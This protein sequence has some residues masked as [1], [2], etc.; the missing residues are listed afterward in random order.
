MEKSLSF[1]LFFC[2][3]LPLSLSHS[4]SLLSPLLPFPSPSLPPSP[5]LCLH[6]YLYM[7]MCAEINVQSFLLFLKCPLLF[8][9][10]LF[11]MFDRVS[12]NDVDWLA[13]EPLGPTCFCPPSAWVTGTSHQNPLVLHEIWGLDSGPPVHL[14]RLSLILSLCMFV[15]GRN[16]Q[17]VWMGIQWYPGDLRV[18]SFIVFTSCL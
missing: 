11:L 14:C 2:P 1:S 7:H 8:Y 13:T 18:D 6:T 15:S 12:P 16:S 9:C 5:P 10:L 4:L 17:K 3:P